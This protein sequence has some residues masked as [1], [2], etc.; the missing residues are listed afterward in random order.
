MPKGHKDKTTKAKGSTE[1]YPKK[2]GKYDGDSQEETLF[3]DR[4]TSAVDQLIQCEKCEMCLCAACE[5]IPENVMTMVSEYNQIHWFC[6]YCDAIVSKAIGQA[7]K[8][9]S[10][11][12]QSRVSLM[13]LRKWSIKQK[14]FLNPK[15]L[16]KKL[17]W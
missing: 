2:G 13:N 1:P 6:Q 7:C 9:L 8:N 4:C 3:C 12:V 11:P 10:K 5:K 15:H 16:H 14:N 17:Q